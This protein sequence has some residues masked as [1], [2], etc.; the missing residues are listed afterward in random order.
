MSLHEAM[1]LHV[2]MRTLLRTRREGGRGRERKRDR[3]RERE[4]RRVG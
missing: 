2:E 3:E 1:E 4:G